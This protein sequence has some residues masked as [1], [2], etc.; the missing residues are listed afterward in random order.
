MKFINRITKETSIVLSLLIV[1]LPAGSALALNSGLPL[2]SNQR[3]IEKGVVN[4]SDD[5][6]HA[7]CDDIWIEKGK[8][9]LFDK[10]NLNQNKNDYV[11]VLVLAQNN[12]PDQ[13][14]STLT[15]TSQTNDTDKLIV[16]SLCSVGV[17]IVGGGIGCILGA[18]LSP[19]DSKQGGLLAGLFIG[20]TLGIIISP[21]FC[22]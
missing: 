3:I 8:A 7:L 14:T 1:V 12:I 18:S 9:G 5:G 19:N 17:G 21:L 6:S 4:K 15:Q 13:S 10:S 22:H 20:M 2:A 16:K 11:G